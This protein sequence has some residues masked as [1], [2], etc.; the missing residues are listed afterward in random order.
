MATAIDME[1][2]SSNGFTI[3]AGKFQPPGLILPAKAPFR[4]GGT[5]NNLLG[6]TGAE[7]FQLLTV[8]PDAP[9]YK[10]ATHSGSCWD[11]KR[12]IMWMFGA[13]THNI[14]A[15]M[16]NA[17]YGWRANDGKFIKQYDAD[18]LIDYRMDAAGVYWADAA[19]TRPW[20]MH[21]YRRLR[22]VPSSSEIEVMY[23]ADQHAYVTP[24]FEDPAQT[25]DNR[26]PP[27]WYYNVVTGK[28]R[29][30]KFGQSVTMPGTAYIHPV[31]FDPTYGWFTDDGSTWT[32]LSTDGVISTVG[33]SGKGN[34]QYHSYLH[35]KDGIAYK[36]GGNAETYLYS[37][38]PL[39]NIAGSTRF[40][41]ASF[42]ALAGKLCQNMASVMRPD[43]KI[44]LFPISGSNVFALILDPVANT[45]VDTGHILSGITKGAGTYEF[46]AE[47]ST[48]HNCALLLSKR[49]AIDRMY[50]YRPP[51]A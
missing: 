10:G 32:R 4:V 7:G 48:Q 44:I 43:G 16:D 11:D 21:S 33:I 17:V 27:V 20:G 3:Y 8:A 12:G 5:V 47:W 36:V 30:H 14:E 26:Q 40:T 1:Y 34:S 51:A 24:I 6:T 28:W 19:K 29:A 42:P 50:C 41:I 45:V 31:G 9:I 39:D 38:H 37:R 25:V 23:D 35:V 49:F 2:F 46:A 13:E 18:P 15:Q 22:W